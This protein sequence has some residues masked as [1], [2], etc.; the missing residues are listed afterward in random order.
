MRH[1]W[2][3]KI[4]LTHRYGNGYVYSSAFCSADEAER[5]LREH[6]GMLDADVEARHLKMKIGRVTQ[7][8]NK[9]DFV[10]V[11]TSDILFICAG[12]FSEQLRPLQQMPLQ[13]LPLQHR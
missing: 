3:W 1:G 9:H 8:W 5:E 12:T 13:I 6:L 2:A 10:Q 7:H 11:D 4:P